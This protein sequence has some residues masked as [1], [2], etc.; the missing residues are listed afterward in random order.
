VIRPLLLASEKDIAAFAEA[1]AFPILPCDL[2]GSQENLWRKQVKQLVDELETRIPK[3]RDSMLGAIGN[4]HATHLLDGALMR[5]LALPAAPGDA[6]VSIEPEAGV[7]L[8]KR[9]PLVPG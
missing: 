8:G 3:V 2:C 4:V 1:K 5:A 6:S 7:S 9:L